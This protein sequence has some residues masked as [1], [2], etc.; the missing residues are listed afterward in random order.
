MLLKNCIIVGLG[1]ICGSLLRWLLLFLNP[2]DLGVYWLIF[3]ENTAGSLLLCFFINGPFR[4]KKWSDSAVLFAG[5]GMLG[6]FTTF[7]TYILQTITLS[8][9]D[10]S[11]SVLYMSGSVASGIIFGFIGWRFGARVLAHQSEGEISRKKE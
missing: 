6:S 2:G 10:I 3:L 4:A 5:S 1:G 8:A 7:S 9:V 11:I